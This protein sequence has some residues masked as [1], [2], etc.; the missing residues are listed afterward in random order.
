[1][2][3][4]SSAVIGSHRDRFDQ[5]ESIEIS[6][7]PAQRSPRGLGTVA[8]VLSYCGRP[9]DALVDG[10]WQTLHGWQGLRRQQYAALG[11]RLSAVCDVPDLE[12][13]PRMVPGVRTV[14]FHG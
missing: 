13:L 1:M 4:V 10:R 8:A 3:I 2:A 14:S 7:A 6:I 9:F 5:I 12:L 11:R